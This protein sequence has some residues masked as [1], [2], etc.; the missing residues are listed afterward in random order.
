MP[1]TR[2]IPISPLTGVLDTR[3]SPD[4][5]PQ[6]GLRMRQNMQTASMGKLRRGKGFQ[7]LFSKTTYN[8]QDFHDQMVGVSGIR[9]PITMLKEFSTSRQILKKIVATQSKIAMLDE[10]GGAYKILGSGYGGTASESAAAPR[11]KSDQLGDYVIFTNDFEPPKYYVLESAPDETTGELIHDIPDLVTIGLTRAALVWQ[12]RNVIFLADVEMDFTRCKNRIVW[13]NFQ[14]PIEFDPAD[15]QSIAGTRDLHLHERILGG[16]PFGNGFLIYT[17]H[18]IWEMTAV[19]GDE[20]F[21]FRRVFNGEQNEQQ[22][23]L[24]FPNTLVALR[25]T[26]IYAGSDGLYEFTQFSPSPQRVEWIHRSSNLFFDNIDT[27]NCQVHIGAADGD[28]VVFYA[29]E[30]GDANHCPSKGL[31]LNRAYQAA[32][33]VDHGFTAACQMHSQEIPTIRDFIISNGI[34]T[35][36]GLIA[37]GY[38]L[39]N[40]GLPNPL[41]SA[42]VDFTPD[43]IYTT[44]S[45]T[46]D[47]AEVEDWTEE[48]ASEH[49]LCTLLAGRRLDDFCSKCQGKAFLAAASSVDWC[50]KQFSEVFYRERCVNPTAIGTTDSNGYT[51]ASGSYLLDGIESIMRFA[52]MWSEGAIVTMSSIGL[53]FIE[54]PQNPPARISLRIGMSAQVKDPNIE[55]CG[56]VWHQHSE[57]E[58]KCQSNKSQ[59]QHLIG[60]TTPGREFSWQFERKGKKL[61]VELRMVGTG[62]DAIFSKIKAE[63]GASKFRQY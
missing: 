18:G 37:A 24:F 17:T 36:A 39:V 5:I 46:V 53:D 56:I 14:G 34:C 10:Y 61:Y 6:G 33:K 51:S 48:S 30:V 60:K 47:T 31:R 32:D 58:V 55:N 41:P 54:V 11:F 63:V 44:V 49:S 26:H 13:S 38:P 52:P 50:I 59:A 3:S 12:W 4:M 19:G 21:A 20:S 23:T 27:A 25:D 29:A 8:N 62:G 1:N 35:I 57:Q 45:Q 15:V 40:E 22:G 43:S 9:Q 42:D 16:A 28:E 2:G 7:K